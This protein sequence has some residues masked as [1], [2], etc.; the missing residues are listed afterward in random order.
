MVSTLCGHGPCVEKVPFLPRDGPGTKITKID[1]H[2]YKRSL[3]N[4]SQT[5]HVCHICRSVGVVPGG[6]MGR[7]SY[8]S[9][10]EC[11]GMVVELVDFDGLLETRPFAMIQSTPPR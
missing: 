6:S 2:G 1:T 10:M 8:A 4:K 11:L 5:L 3:I 9:P 7:Q